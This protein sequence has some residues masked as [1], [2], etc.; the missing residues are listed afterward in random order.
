MNLDTSRWKTFLLSSLYNIRMG[1]KL[2][3]NKMGEDNPSVNFVSRISYNNGVDLKVDRIDNITPN[4][5]GLMTVSLGG[6][7]LGSC[8]IQTEDFYTAQNIAILEPKNSLMNKYVNQFIC[9]LVKFECR[10]KY[11]AF[12]RELNTHISRD[13]EINLPIERDTNGQPVID[14]DCIYSPDGYIP[15][16]KFMEHFIK[17]LRHKPLTTKNRKAS[18]ALSISQ[19]KYFFISKKKNRPGLF[20]INNCK[21][22]CAGDLEEGNDINY[23]G[24]KKSDNGVMKRVK[25]DMTLLSK[26]NGIMF[27]CDGEGSVGYTN[28]MKEDFIGSTTTSI[29]YNDELNELNAL[30]IVTVLDKERFKYSYGRKYRKHIDEIQIKLPVLHNE[31]GS[32]FID[33]RHKYSAEGYLP[34]WKFMEQYIKNLPYGDRL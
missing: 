27:I 4:D 24:A 1:D 7:Y 23:I 17:S 16:W 22:G 14:R 6:E 5:A 8:Y 34:D 20:K 9:T 26:G 33:K 28:Y 15:N 25:L 30:F 19:W 21:C 2:D 31:D 32:I 29:G 11:Y 3:K 10:T 13:F 12:G 18:P